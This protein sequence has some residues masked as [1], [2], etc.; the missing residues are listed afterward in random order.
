MNE[1]NIFYC[2]VE[3][4]IK[5]FFSLD[6][7]KPNSNEP[8]ADGIELVPINPPSPEQHGSEDEESLLLDPEFIER[9]EVKVEN[10]SSCEGGKFILFQKL[11]NLGS[12]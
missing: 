6:E 10:V 9:A 3:F 2:D 4:K 7:E 1:W 11:F 8:P 5:T 12:I